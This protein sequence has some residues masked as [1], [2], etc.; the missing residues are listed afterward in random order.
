MRITIA[1]VGRAKPGVLRDLYEHYTG[2]L[3]WPVSL[4]EVEPKGRLS[5]GELVAKEA[6]LLL[7]CVPSGARVIALD[8]RGRDL[9]SPGLAALLG[10]WRDD[11]IGDIAVL[12]GG[13]D[14]HDASVRQRADLLL[15]FGRATWPH[16]MVRGM[17]AE[18]LYRAQQ[19]LAGHPYHRE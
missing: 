18:Q 10:G 12:I 11:G 19:I 15:A 2:R 17:L 6:E 1:A 14:G 7:A 8:E 4:K 3:R 9:D 13:A 5:G 16:M